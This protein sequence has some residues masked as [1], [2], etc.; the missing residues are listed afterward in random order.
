MITISPTQFASRQIKPDP[1]AV[2]SPAIYSAET[3]ASPSQTPVVQFEGALDA[4]KIKWRLKQLEKNNPNIFKYADVPVPQWL[5]QFE[6]KDRLLVLKLLEA[7][8]YIDLNQMRRLSQKLHQQLKTRL[9][10][11][12]DIEKTRFTH[13]AVGK[14]GGVIQYLYRQANT[15]SNQSVMSFDRALS[16]IKMGKGKAVETL[17][18]VEDFLGSGKEAEYFFE[19]LDDALKKVDQRYKNIVF[20]PIIAYQEGLDLL[21]E[22]FPWLTVIPAK[23]PPKLLDDNHPVFSEKEQLQFKEMLEKYE[24]LYPRDLYPNSQVTGPFG[25]RDGQSMIV[26]S[27]NTP[28]NSLPIFWSAFDNWQPL[29]T[30]Y[31]SFNADTGHWRFVAEGE[32]LL[33]I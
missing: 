14:S 20:M 17:V 25:Y 12:F 33:E 16:P 19:R 10:D 5:A 30:R 9:G 23:V 28:S 26:F 27:H 29:F 1:L 13:F 22:K 4:L 8:D 24:R 31:D 3:I 11:D 18:V 21:E 6:A 15:L 32:K 2:F 7:V